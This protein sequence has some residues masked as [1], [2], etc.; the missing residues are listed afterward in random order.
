MKKVIITTKNWN[1][2]YRNIYREFETD[3]HLEKYLDAIYKSGYSKV[4]GVHDVTEEK[5]K[6]DIINEI[7]NT[8]VRLHHSKEEIK[9][10]L[11]PKSLEQ[12]E[13]ILDELKYNSIFANN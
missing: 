5:L 11:M 6:E 4:I 3:R 13:K 9:K 2:V 1:G 7:Y 12:L 8:S 10:D